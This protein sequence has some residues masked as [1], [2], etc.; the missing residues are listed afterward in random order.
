MVT[1][2]DDYT[3]EDYIRDCA[4]NADDDWNEMLEIVDRVALIP[5][6]G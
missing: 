1:A 5:E 6:E 4:E 3:A 2:S